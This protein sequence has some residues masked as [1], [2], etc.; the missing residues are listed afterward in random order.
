LLKLEKL[1]TVTGHKE[2]I[3][4]AEI[5]SP[6]K[7]GNNGIQEVFF[8]KSPRPEM[9]TPGRIPRIRSGMTMP[10]ISK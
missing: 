9:K 8:T 1:L 10:V 3:F 6:G 7:V 2:W 4:L 5:G